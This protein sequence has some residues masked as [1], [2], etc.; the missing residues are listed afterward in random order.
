MPVTESGDGV[1]GILLWW[2]TRFLLAHSPPNFINQNT[3]LCTILQAEGGA[4]VYFANALHKD[5]SLG[6]Y[7]EPAS[8]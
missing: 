5:L 4:N 1:E 3:A 8:Q 2:A 6:E 7:Y